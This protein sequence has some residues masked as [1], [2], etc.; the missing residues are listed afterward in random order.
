[1]D[2]VVI[3]VRW[4]SMVALAYAYEP[5]TADR[6]FELLSRVDYR[7]AVS[8]AEREAIFRF[9]YEAYRR[10]RAIPANPSGRFSDAY[11]DLGDV[12][13]FGVHVDGVLVGSVRVHVVTRQ[14]PCGPSLEPF[15]DILAPE[16]RAGRVIVD[17]T[18]FVTDRAMT[19]QV[20]GLPHVTLRLCWMA[21][22]HFQADHFLAAVRPEHQAFYRRTFQHRL[23]APARTYPMRDSP[24][25][26]MSVSYW[27]AVDHVRR[28]YPFY[29]SSE[30]ERRMLFEGT[31]SA[32]ELRS[33]ARA[34]LHTVAGE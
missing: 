16:L 26:L 29:R 22:E 24:I 25:S 14:E 2:I 34:H 32:P 27:E 3:S 10:E 33:V 18:R 30:F 15:R 1:M 6:V 8:K 9:R 7:L 11:D 21:A 31:P 12:R 13:L 23:I 5:N 20:F 28:R 4:D 17:S 19:Q